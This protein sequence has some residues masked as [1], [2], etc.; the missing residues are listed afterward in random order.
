[1][2]SASQWKR[3]F[4][5]PDSWMKGNIF[6]ALFLGLGL[7]GSPQPHIQGHPTPHLSVTHGEQGKPGFSCRNVVASWACHVGQRK[8][9]TL[10]ERGRDFIQLLSVPWE[11]S[12]SLVLKEEQQ[13]LPQIQ[14][15]PEEATERAEWLPQRPPCSGTSRFGQLS[16]VARKF[17]SKF[18]PSAKKSL[19]ITW[20]F[21]V[22]TEPAHHWSSYKRTNSNQEM[23][24]HLKNAKKNPSAAAQ[25]LKP[26]KLIL[27][28]QNSH[29][30][31]LSPSFFLSLVKGK[32]SF[33][34]K[35]LKLQPEAP[36]GCSIPPGTSQSV[37][38]V[39]KTQKELPTGKPYSLS[40]KFWLKVKFGKT[41]WL[42]KQHQSSA[43]LQF[44]REG[45]GRKEMRMQQED[46]SVHV[47][48]HFSQIYI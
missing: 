8:S 2:T 19:G 9:Q 7:A 24:Q 18:L 30:L 28:F 47:H 1:M 33:L 6:R 36:P 17:H 5:N 38:N 16:P 13:I 20:E 43:L 15:T 40:Y 26:C 44:A 4:T 34:K 31:S 48:T 45:K 21:P 14:E 27:P 29:V 11:L 10:P 23:L 42:E 12:L 3:C 46:V 32:G 35:P 39:N 25:T 37:W 22:R 41:L